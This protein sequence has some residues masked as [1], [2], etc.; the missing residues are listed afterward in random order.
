MSKIY[1]TSGNDDLKIE[2]NSGL[3]EN[4]LFFSDDVY[5]RTNVKENEVA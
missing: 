1:H 2:D 3:F 5:F 4:F